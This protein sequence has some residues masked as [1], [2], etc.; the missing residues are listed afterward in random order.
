M[1][2]VLG[3]KRAEPVKVQGEN[4]FYTHS[5]S[6]HTTSFFFEHVYYY[7][8]WTLSGGLLANHIPESNLGLIFFPGMELSYLLLPELKAFASF[9]TSLR[10]PTFTDLYYSGPTN[11]G[12]SAL[13][14][15]KSATLES[16]FKWSSP[17]MQAH[18]VI[19]YQRG[20]DMI[21]WVKTHPDDLWQ[22]QNLTRINS[23]GTEI[24]LQMNLRKQ[25]GN[26]FPNRVSVS[27]FH[28]HLEKQHEEIISNYVLDHIRY[29]VVGSV[30]QLVAKNL[31][32]DLKIVFQD[33]EGTY[34]RFYEGNGGEEV[35]YKPFWMF[36]TKM[37]YSRQK[38]NVYLS[39][40]NL[41]NVFYYDIG[42]VA[43]PGRWMKAGFLYRLDLN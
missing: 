11:V 25:F 2:N 26:P 4:A 40:N 3:V 43:Q 21:D 41:F 29:K 13:K 42:N 35:N 17:F 31:S 15:E 32:L 1:S 28:N 38:W 20:K 22:P 34:T 33:R 24:Q 9:N 6:R 12:N 37:I 5:K 14:P 8:N 27:F 36:D 16:G 39:V 18:G 7:N 10:M 23:L 30:N 19:F